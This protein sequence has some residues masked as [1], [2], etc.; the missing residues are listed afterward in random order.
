[1]SNMRPCQETQGR[2]GAV[3]AMQKVLEFA[4][5]QGTIGYKGFDISY[6]GDEPVGRVRRQTVH[7]RGTAQLRQRWTSYSKVV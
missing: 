2:Y 7:A 1:M 5:G 4:Y 3:E 6:R